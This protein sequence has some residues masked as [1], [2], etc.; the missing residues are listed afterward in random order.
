AG[1]RWIW[2]VVVIAACEPKLPLQ[3]L[4]RLAAGPPPLQPFAVTSLM[5]PAGESMIWEVRSQGLTIGR[6]ELAI[7]ETEVHSRFKTNQLASVFAAA[8]HEATTVVDRGATRPRAT[9]ELLQ[10]DDETTR[11]RAELD[12]AHVDVGTARTT[13]PGGNIGQTLHTALGWLRAWA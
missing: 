7:G 2:L 4:P 8:R 10:I 12:G 9:S 13:I 1:M 11:V 6:V 5:L 3:P